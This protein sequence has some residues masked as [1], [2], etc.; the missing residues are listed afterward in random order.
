MTNILEKSTLMFTVI[1]SNT[2]RKKKKKKR[3]KGAPKKKALLCFLFIIYNH[4]HFDRT[5][6]KNNTNKLSPIMSLRFLD[7]IIECRIIKNMNIMMK[8]LFIRI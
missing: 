4:V 7:T 3:V 6:K 1:E 8:H 5:E 2:H